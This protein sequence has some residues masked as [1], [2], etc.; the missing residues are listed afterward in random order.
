[1][2]RIQMIFTDFYFLNSIFGFGSRSFGEGWGF[3][4]QIC[5]SPLKP[6]EVLERDNSAIFDS[7]GL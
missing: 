5:N 1:M 7:F 3:R 4:N 6:L 2:T